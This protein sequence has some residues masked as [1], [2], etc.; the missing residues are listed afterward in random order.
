MQTKHFGIRTKTKYAYRDLRSEEHTSELQSRPHLVCRLLL[1]KKKVHALIFWFL[2]TL[3]VN[4]LFIFS[5]VI[6]CIL[7][8]LGTWLICNVVAYYPYVCVTFVSIHIGVSG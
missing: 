2:M 7:V 8:V 3:V 1:E 6:I 4:S 5:T